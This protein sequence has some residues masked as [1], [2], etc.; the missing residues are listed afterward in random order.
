MTDSQRQSSWAG[1]SVLA[2]ALFIAQG[3]ATQQYVMLR[4]EPHTPLATPLAL[5]AHSGPKPSRWTI[6]FLRQHDLLN[7]ERLSKRWALGEVARIHER[8]PS[9]ASCYALAELSF[10]AARSAEM[11]SRERAQEL[12][13][14]GTVHSYE[15]LFDPKY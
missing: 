14:D 13:W 3:C 1:P 6:Q 4:S 10:L 5:Y 8:Y 9:P 2:A 7:K 12:Y 11:Q 15:Y